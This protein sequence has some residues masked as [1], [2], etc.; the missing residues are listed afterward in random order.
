V[1]GALSGCISETRA[2]LSK[3]GEVA[4]RYFRVQTRRGLQ[5]TP[6]PRSLSSLR[7]GPGA[8]VTILAVLAG[9]A[10]TFAYTAGWLSPLRLTPAKLVAALNAIHKSGGLR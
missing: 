2:A 7:I 9:S 6:M 5:R 10:A 1:R 3:E 8:A 4:W